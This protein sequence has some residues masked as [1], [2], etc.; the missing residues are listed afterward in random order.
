MRSVASTPANSARTPHRRHCLKNNFTIVIQQF[1]CETGVVVDG[2]ALERTLSQYV[3]RAARHERD[4][5]HAAWH[6][7]RRAGNFLEPA[8]RK[9]SDN[10]TAVFEAVHETREFVAHESA[11]NGIHRAVCVAT[12]LTDHGN[13]GQRSCKYSVP[14]IGVKQKHP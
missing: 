7:A 3:P 13:A 4:P 12:R 1:A 14:K 10:R 8:E 9:V 5:S 11:G 2:P 6:V